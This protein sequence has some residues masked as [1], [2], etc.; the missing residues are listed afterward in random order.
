LRFFPKAAAILLRRQKSV[1]ARLVRSGGY[2][3]IEQYELY[4]LTDRFFYDTPGNRG[5]GSPDFP[6]TALPVPQNWECQAT[7]IWMSYAPEEHVLPKQGWKIHVSSSIDDA[8]HALQAVWDYCVPRGLAFKFLRSQAVMVM[9]N[10]KSAF[11][12]SSGKLMTI[13]PADVAQLE[14]VLK[15]LDGIL[16]GIEG[17]YI[18]SDLRY[19]DGPLFVRYGAFAEQHCVDDSGERVLALEDDQGR[20]VPDVR[21]PTFTYPPWVALPEFLKPHL[22]ARNA[23]TTAGLPYEIESVVQFS[24]GGGVDV[25]RVV[26][27]G[28]RVGG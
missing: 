15:E 20:L 13:Y 19:G 16:S 2:R 1:V 27:T 22:A 21:G 14:L 26:G 28:V 9:F 5:A 23:V 8:E 10:S 7:D 24:N 6:I 11:R 3:V 18:L 25:G 4:C 17:P 12:G